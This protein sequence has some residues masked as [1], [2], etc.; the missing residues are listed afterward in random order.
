MKVLLVAFIMSLN[1]AIATLGVF[2]VST[3]FE[4]LELKKCAI[5]AVSFIMLS[6]VPS[7]AGFSVDR[8]LAMAIE[9]LGFSSTCFFVLLVINF[10][11]R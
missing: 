4:P 2:L 3:Q 9:R 5:I 10:W 6:Y 7:G 1:I 8:A 11:S